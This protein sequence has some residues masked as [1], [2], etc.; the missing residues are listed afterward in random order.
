MTTKRR[1]TSRYLATAMA[2]A[3]ALAALPACSD[4]DDDDTAADGDTTT[5]EA[6][7]TGEE[8]EAA[9]GES[10]DDPFCEGFLG[11][12]QA[13]AEAPEDESEMPGFVEERI[14]PNLALIDGNEPEDIADEVITMTDAVEELAATGDF[15]AFESPEFL[16]ASA[17]VYSSL[18]DACDI[19]VV[20]FSAVDYEYEG[21]P[22][23][24]APGPTSFVMANDGSEAHEFVLVKLGDDVELT[25]EEL[26]AMPEAESEQYIDAFAGGTFAPA[27]ATSG[28]MAD[29]TPGRW[30]YVCFL[31]VGSVDGAEGTGP[32][33]FMEGMSGEF[34][35]E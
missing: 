3:L 32:P 9:A 20:E 14:E 19:P 35:V 22:E 17:T 10:S 8:S 27:D 2:V 18:D 26:L 30:V 11:V 5:T 24:L 7:A 31:P 13:F 16:E 33:H 21:V 6:A 34:T 4:D 1:T 28:T 12:E 23:T 15:S 25:L 29:L